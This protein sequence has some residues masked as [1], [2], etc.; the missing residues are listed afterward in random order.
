MM[1]AIKFLAV[2]AFFFGHAPASEA[3]PVLAT[4]RER[5]SI[6]D[7]WRFT[8][9]DSTSFESFRAPDRKTFNGLCLVIIRGQAGKPR[10]LKLTAKTKS[11]KIGTVTV[12]T[13][14][15]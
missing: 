12:T 5:I 3:L 13:L 4:A 8:K 9:S 7:H 6:N 10:T 1:A 11:L 2:A 15:P 14:L